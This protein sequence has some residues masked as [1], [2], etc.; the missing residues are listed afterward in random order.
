MR[1]AALKESA[2]DAGRAV[3]NEEIPQMGGDGGAIIL[4]ADGSASMPFNTE[5]MYRGWIGSDGVPHVA[6]YS[7]DKLAP[8]VAA[9]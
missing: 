7:T 1:M 5:G 2:A 8:P 9:H 4:G 6:I 3:I